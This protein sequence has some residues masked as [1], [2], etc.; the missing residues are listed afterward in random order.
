MKKHEKLKQNAPKWTPRAPNLDPK[1]TK[2][3]T[4][5]NHGAILDQLCA[6]TPQR[7]KTRENLAKIYE[8]RTQNAIAPGWKLAPRGLQKAILEHLWPQA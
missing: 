4:K 6:E 2:R 1:S 5:N 8:H 3:C 7:Q